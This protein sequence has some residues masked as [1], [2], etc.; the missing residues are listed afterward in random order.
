MTIS[1]LFVFADTIICFSAHANESMLSTTGTEI[2]VYLVK[3]VGGR[4]WS[5]SAVT[6]I[7]DSKEKTIKVGKF[8]Y[9]INKNLAYGQSDDGRGEYMYVAGDYYFNL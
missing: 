4:A 5:K 7:Y 1:S 6:A 8:T 9:S 2:T 3:Q